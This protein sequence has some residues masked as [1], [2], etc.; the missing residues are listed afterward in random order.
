MT[1]S[2]QLE[3]RKLVS[4]Y[5]A[6]PAPSYIEAYIRDASAAR[7]NSF[8]LHAAGTTDVF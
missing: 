2:F 3:L 4:N 1:N 5:R 6:L 7:Q 8:F